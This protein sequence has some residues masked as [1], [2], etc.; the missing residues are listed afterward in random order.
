MGTPQARRWRAI[1]LSLLSAAGFLVLV[2]I[3]ATSV[4]L[5]DQAR[6][7]NAWVVHTLEVENQISTL[8][9]RIRTAESAVRGY[10]LTG[11]QR[12]LTEHEAAT[13]GIVPDIDTLTRLAGDNK[14]QF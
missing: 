8:L 2:A 12:F 4:I 13:A 6:E 5:V 7:D 9:L 10:V 3:S 11:E 1:G 14:I